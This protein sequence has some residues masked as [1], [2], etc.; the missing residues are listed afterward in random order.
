MTD[1]VFSCHSVCPGEVRITSIEKTC[2]TIS[3]HWISPLDENGI[4]YEVRFQYSLKKELLRRPDSVVASSTCKKWTVVNLPSDAAVKFSLTAINKRSKAG[5]S[6]H[7][8]V[9]TKKSC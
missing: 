5:P 9:K 4:P 6:T 7:A 2:C 1:A 8:T 3:I